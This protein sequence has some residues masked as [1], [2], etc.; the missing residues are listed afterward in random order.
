MED[1]LI[2]PQFCPLPSCFDLYYKNRPLVLINVFN[3]KDEYVLKK[4]S[5][6]R[7]TDGQTDYRI[8][9]HWLEESSL[10]IFYIYRE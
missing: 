9:V 10:K 5:Y 2:F 1:E 8:N 4:I 7:Q 3:N 6:Y